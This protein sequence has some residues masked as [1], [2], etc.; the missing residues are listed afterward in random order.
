MSLLAR[1]LSD[2][3]KAA[4]HCHDATVDKTAAP[5]PPPSPGLSWDK[6]TLAP[7]K[8]RL[9]MSFARTYAGAYLST[10]AADAVKEWNTDEPKFAFR[11]NGG[12]DHNSGNVSW[13]S[14]SWV[15]ENVSHIC[16][17][18][19]S[20][21]DGLTQGSGADSLFTSGGIPARLSASRGATRTTP[22][23]HVDLCAPPSAPSQRLGIEAALS[24][25]SAAWRPLGPANPAAAA[26]V[27]T[28]LAGLPGPDP[29][30]AAILTEAQCFGTSP[31]WSP[32]RQ[33][34]TMSFWRDPALAPAD[35]DPDITCGEW[36]DFLTAW[37]GKS[38]QSTHVAVC[39]AAIASGAG[40]VPAVATAATAG[41]T[42]LVA[43]HNL[44]NT[45]DPAQAQWVAERLAE[46]RASGVIPNPA[47]LSALLASAPAAI[48]A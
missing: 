33:T 34:M 7:L 21:P 3:R 31:L 47:Y 38:S 20:S 2:A 26:P 44:L 39:F 17:G 13:R 8:E 40:A 46:A 5:A 15:V 16:L 4:V 10:P 32:Q 48:L 6:A 1:L 36:A 14:L 9:P 37:F 29:A 42:L 35:A 45:L 30:R 23:T 18:V 19:A 12:Y 25:V 24:A 27:V 22:F 43:G 28:Y 41:A 11:A